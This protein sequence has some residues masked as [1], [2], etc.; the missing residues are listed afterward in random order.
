MGRRC[1]KRLFKK[2]NEF[3]KVAVEADNLYQIDQ[4]LK[5]KAKTKVKEVLVSWLGWPKKNYSWIS[6]NTIKKT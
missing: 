5:R 6:E 3:Q 4:I 1:Y 2:K